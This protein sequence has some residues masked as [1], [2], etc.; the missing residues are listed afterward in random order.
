MAEAIF[1]INVCSIFF[2]N[3]PYFAGKDIGIY[4]N[5]KIYS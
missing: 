5:T 1:V 4:P 2:I 3:Y